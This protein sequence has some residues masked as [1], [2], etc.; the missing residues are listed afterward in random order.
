[1]T[2]DNISKSVMTALYMYVIV[3]SA[4]QTTKIYLLQATNNFMLDF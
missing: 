1:M 3:F 4:Y 2:H